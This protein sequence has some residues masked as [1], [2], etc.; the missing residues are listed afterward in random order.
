MKFIGN[1][2]GVDRGE[3]IVKVWECPICS[4]RFKSKSEPKMC[5]ECQKKENY[6]RKEEERI[7]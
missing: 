2:F 3:E 5:I 4:S 7:L 6:I 1:T